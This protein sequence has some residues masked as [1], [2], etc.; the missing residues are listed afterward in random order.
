MPWRILFHIFCSAAA[1]AATAS[2]SCH[3]PKPKVILLP[4]KK[5]DKMENTG[6]HLDKKRPTG[7]TNTNK[8]AWQLRL[9]ALNTS[10]T[11][12]TQTAISLCA[13][14][15]HL[16]Q[17]AASC[18][19]NPRTLWAKQSTT[20]YGKTMRHHLFTMLIAKHCTAL[21]PE[22]HVWS[23]KSTAHCPSLPLHNEPPTAVSL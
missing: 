8:Y 11:E 4:L 18:N 6:R 10:H 3:R 22:Q 23:G 19:C 14:A 15:V 20:T 7:L 2:S 13:E 1:A 17:Y 12:S 9:S 16:K 5:L 21:C